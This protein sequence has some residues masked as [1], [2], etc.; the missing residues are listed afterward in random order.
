MKNQVGENKA[1]VFVSGGVDSAVTAILAKE[2]L[3]KNAIYYFID[4]GLQRKGEKK[5]IKAV[6]RKSGVNVK[7][8]NAGKEFLKKLSSCITGSKKRN[9]LGDLLVEKALQIAKQEN[10]RHLVFGTIKNDL[11]VCREYTDCIPGFEL[12]EPFIDTTKDQV[13]ELAKQLG[14]PEEVWAKQHFPGVGFAVRIEGEVTTKKL[15]LIRKLTALVENKTKELK[16]DKNLWGYFPFLLENKIEGKYA[17][18]LRLVESGLGLMAEIPEISKSQ[19]IELR[20]EIFR[21]EPEV[22]RV[23]FDLT[24]KPINLIEFM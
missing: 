13:I 20:D 11:M 4:N 19:F 21:R 6:F 2:A 22:G 9:L 16:L 10:S 1:V 18:V 24:P 15:A 12:I 3:G 8:F 7:I 17:I 5:R 14:L 23:Y